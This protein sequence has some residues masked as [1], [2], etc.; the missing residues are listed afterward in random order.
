MP[1]FIHSTN[2]HEEPSR[3][4]G[5]GCTEVKEKDRVFSPKVLPVCGSGGRRES[6]EEMHVRSAE[7][8]SMGVC[9]HLSQGS[10]PGQR[11]PWKGWKAK[12]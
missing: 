10:P 6:P 11:P 8:G 1:F 4:L 5:V 7:Q 2:T 9:E 3:I 12:T